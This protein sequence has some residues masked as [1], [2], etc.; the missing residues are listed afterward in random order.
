MSSR[1]NWVLGKPFL[2]KYF[3]Y[4][5]LEKKII[6]F[7]NQNIKEN[8]NESNDK[9]KNFLYISLIL[10]LLIIIGVLGY[11]M[12]KVIYKYR[13]SRQKGDELIDEDED[14]NE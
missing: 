12:A 8:E 4:F 1:K 10:L 11:F 6:G 13:N 9:F 2:K 3:F 7:F 14:I 5:S